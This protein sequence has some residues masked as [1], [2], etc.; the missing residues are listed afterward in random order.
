MPSTTTLV[1]PGTPDRR[2]PVVH[3]DDLLKFCT[4]FKKTI[5]E[6]LPGGSKYKIK[7]YRRDLSDAY[8]EIT[9]PAGNIC[10]HIEVP[11]VR[12]LKSVYVY[13]CWNGCDFVRLREAMENESISDAFA[14]VPTP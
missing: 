9:D 13:F 1:M 10:L 14:D 5:R 3:T 8:V 12:Y 4:K 7:P 6:K 11:N 2:F